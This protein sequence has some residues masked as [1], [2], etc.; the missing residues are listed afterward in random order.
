MKKLSIFLLLVFSSNLNFAMVTGI[1]FDVRFAN[2]PDDM[3]LVVAKGKKVGI[4]LPFALVSFVAYYPWKVKSNS[5]ENKFKFTK[6]E[7]EADEENSISMA[8]ADGTYTFIFDALAAGNVDLTFEKS[9]NMQITEK[10]L[11]ILIED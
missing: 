9:I 3:T 11:R 8:G 10:K 4:E 6:R 1:D 5:D 2:P 7:F